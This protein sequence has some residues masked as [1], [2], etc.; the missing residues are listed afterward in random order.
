MLNYKVIGILNEIYFAIITLTLFKSHN[1]DFGGGATCDM[2]K[3]LGH[4]TSAIAMT[5]PIAETLLD[6]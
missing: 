3:C 4:S 1:L 6:R 5:Q 2:R